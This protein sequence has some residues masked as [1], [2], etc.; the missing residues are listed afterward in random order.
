MTK[1]QF[2]LFTA[3]I[4]FLFL[5]SAVSA[6]YYPDYSYGNSRETVKVERTKTEVI[7]HPFGTERKTTKTTETSNINNFLP[8]YYPGKYYSQN[9]YPYTGP[10]SSRNQP[11]YYGYNYPKSNW[12]YDGREGYTNDYYYKPKYDY[13]QDSYNWRY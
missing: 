13:M 11:V 1:I 10:S 2:K 5:I 9:F 7:H 4:L 12:Y 3:F 8:R 6:Y